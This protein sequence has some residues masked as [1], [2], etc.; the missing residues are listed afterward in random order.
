MEP[1]IREA[2]LDD[3]HTLFRF[4]QNVINAE[5]PFDPTIKRA[6]INYYDI[7]KMISAANVR[8]V[9]AEHGKEIIG[10]GYARIEDAKIYLKH[11][12]HAYL[13]FMY[14]EPG[15]R[16]KGVNQLVITD[17]KQWAISQNVTELRLEV[18]YDNI[19]AIKAYEKMGFTRLMIEMR[20]DILSK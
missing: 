3:L 6:G 9:V 1:L 2:A 18:Y 15:Y 20:L 11:A 4:E 19:A 5:R 10:C 8:L 16:G 14:V 12:K 13:G 7:K 17:L